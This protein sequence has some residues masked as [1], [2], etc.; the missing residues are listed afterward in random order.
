MTL[1]PNDRDHNGLA[2][3]LVWL[4]GIPDGAPRRTLFFSV[5]AHSMILLALLRSPIPTFVKPASIV[6]GRNGTAMTQIYWVTE[7][8]DPSKDSG[9]GDASSHEASRTDH[10]SKLE[11]QRP[12]KKKFRKAVELANSADDSSA[13]DRGG[14]HQAAAAGSPFG[15][16]TYG[17]L[18]GLEV[19]PAYPVMGSDPIA[20]PGDVPAGFEGDVIIEVMI[21]VQGN[22]IGKSVTQGINPALDAK[23]M[24][25]LANWRFRPATR[26]GVP[27]AS[28][29]DVYFHFRA[30]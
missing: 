9:E 14:Q 18:F 23:S 11:W 19:R 2:S 27:I 26:N 4:W 8:D 15:S 30:H 28:K 17:T 6:A 12:A 13:Q 3:G 7:R 1:L 10:R 21:D 20:E 24:A 22:I 25:A 29:H 16:L 5:A